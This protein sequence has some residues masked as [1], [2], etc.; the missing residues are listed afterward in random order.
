MAGLTG[1]RLPWRKRYDWFAILFLFPT[2]AIIF[3]FHIL[4]IFYSFVLSL[5]RWDL[6][7]EAQYVG[8][9]NFEKLLRDPLLYKS[10][11]N[12][13]IYAVVS[14]PLGIVS[15]LL[16]AVL[17]NSRIRGVGVYRTIYFIPVVTSLV[18]IS[19]VWKW[20]FHPNFGLLN[21]LL[22]SFGLPKQKWL[23]DPQLAMPCIIAMS[24]W[25]GL[26]YNVVLF[27]TGLKNIPR[28]LY[29]AAVVDGA[30]RWHQFRFITWPMLS[31]VT[32]FVLVMSTIGSFQVFAQIYMM[33][34]NGGPLNST[35]VI[36]FYLYKVA[37]KDFRFGY[38]AAI[39]L[40]L[41]VIIFAMTILQKL[42]VEKRVHYS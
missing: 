35:M 32:F 36:V 39:A 23:L 1:R 22:L 4:P 15:A 19:L 10:I 24:I 29:E 20:V 5:F 21:K 40:V 7:G 9:H 3:T 8:L 42:L 27:L 28:H 6:I 25:K 37:F 31:P 14:V 18:A 33:T 26:G 38:G 34:P 16:I 41:F 11:R 2:L 13:A 17:L 12:T 30:G